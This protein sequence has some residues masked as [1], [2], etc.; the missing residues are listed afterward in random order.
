MYQGE[1][2]ALLGHNGAGPTLGVSEA[3]YYWFS[4][5]GFRVSVG[6]FWAVMGFS[7]SFCGC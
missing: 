3:V 7:V 5:V 6:L 1:V 4:G 2:F